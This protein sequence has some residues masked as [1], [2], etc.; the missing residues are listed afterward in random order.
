MAEGAVVMD[1]PQEKCAVAA[2]VSRHPVARPLFF[3][4]RTLQHRGQEYAGIATVDER[5]IHSVRGKGL[6]HQV[7]TEDNIDELTGNAG[8][9]HLLYSIKLSKRENIQPVIVKTSEGS[10]AISHNGIIVNS[11][12]LR[13][14]LRE[15]GHI[16]FTDTEEEAMVYL[17]TKE[18]HRGKSVTEAIRLAMRKT[19]GSY[20]LTF[21][22]QDRVFALRDPMGNRPLCLG[23]LPDGGFM[24]VSESVAIQVLGAEFL[25]DV[26]PGELVELTPDRLISYQL[27]PETHK[28]HCFFEWV[29]FAR[30]DSR[31]DG[32]F[33]YDVRFRIGERLAKDNPVEADLVSPIPD[34]GRAH[35]I[36][37][38]HGSGI[39]YLEGLIKNRYVT[40]TFIM[41]DRDAQ[42]TSVRLKVNVLDHLVAGKRIILVDDSIVRGTT[43]REI[44]S[45]LRR[46]G[47]AEV[48]VRVGSPPLRHPC[49]LGIDMT[50]RD[51]FIA[52][53]RTVEEVEK[54]IGVDSL[55]YISPKG[56]VESIGLPAEQLCLGCIIGEYPLKL[57]S[58]RM[59]FQHRVEDYLSE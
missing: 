49:Y 12:D 22:I 17:I 31:I 9:G 10:M 53:D 8:I 4:L 1:K 40:R 41:P 55:A 25:R 37:Y 34:S 42:R 33:G 45:L 48:H 52:H 7:V 43:I 26:E 23:R 6:V 44:A 50:T 36:G 54:E 46:R 51:E 39:P 3:S 58:E 59:R 19:E 28:A 57:P 20:A 29:Y 24:A 21:I 35:A 2:I 11:P 16:F 27:F 18:L 32:I 30:P 56:L 5:G 47:A 38:A 15:E 14:K 13:N